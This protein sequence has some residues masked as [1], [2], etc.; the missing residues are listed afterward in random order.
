[1]DGLQ[2]E[3]YLVAAAQEVKQKTVALEVVLVLE[4]V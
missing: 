2:L 3:D 4:V 1:M